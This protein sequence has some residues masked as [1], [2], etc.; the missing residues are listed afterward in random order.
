M[1]KK[2]K[3]LP[4]RSKIPVGMTWDLLKMYADISLWEKD[5]KSLAPLLADFMEFKGRIGDSAETFRDAFKANDALERRLEKVYTYAHLSADEDTANSANSSRLDQ[6]TAKFAEIEGETAWFDPEILALPEEKLKSYL[7]SP[8][9]SFYK[10]TLEE[11]IKDRP[12]TLSEPEEKI[13]GTVSDALS[14]PYKAFTMLNNA[15]MKFPKV[16]DGRGGEIELTHG[17]YIKF[18]ENADREVRK[19]AFGGMYDTVSKYRNTFAAI[20]DGA[21]KT[22]TFEAKTRNFP[23]TLRASLHDDNIPDEVYTNLISTVRKNLPFLHGYFELRRKT[24][25][26]RKLDMFDLYCPIV[27][28]CEIEISW[29]DACRYVKESLEP[30]G[31]EYCAVIDKALKDR[32]IDV[33]ECRGKRCGAY[34]SGCYDSAPYILMNYSGTMND[35]FTLAHELGHSMHSY[36]S[37]R[38]QDFHYASYSIFAA[39]AASTTN[40]LLLHSYLMRKFTDGKMRLYLVNRLA[41]EIRCTVYRQTMFAEFEKLIHEKRENGTPLSADELCSSYFKINSEYHG[42]S[43]VP[44]DRIRMEWGRIPH[45]YYNYYV[46]K[47]ATGFSAA[48]KFSENILSGDKTKLDAYKGFL[49]AGDTKDVLDILRDAGVDLSRPEPVEACMR[50]FAGTVRQ[51]EEGLTNAKAQ[52]RKAKPVG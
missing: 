11:L 12:H 10:R 27:P 47:Y 38:K 35:V 23:S 41:E 37:N 33:L 13:L 26:L 2:S 30:M 48:I 3:S 51:L 9:L 42:P 31:P 22:H 52:S 32:W 15:D 34:S 40:E 18:V 25:K 14:T 49:G 43:V 4:E 16:P 20:L 6:V 45:F 50:H 21:V 5:F 28:D 39:E 7:E 44:D 19:A 29:E 46:Y 8:A 24:L 17:N 1:K 36:F